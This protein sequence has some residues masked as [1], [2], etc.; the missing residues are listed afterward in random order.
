VA[1]T[2]QEGPRPF[3]LDLSGL[4]THVATDESALDLGGRPGIAGRREKG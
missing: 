4:L 2:G 1:D 3:V